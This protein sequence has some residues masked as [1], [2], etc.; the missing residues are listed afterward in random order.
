MDRDDRALTAGRAAATFYAP[1]LA[2]GVARISLGQEAAHHARVRRLSLGDAVRATSGTGLLGAGVL[3]H[4]GGDA[5]EIRIE[6]VQ[7]VS[8]RVVVRLYVPVGDRE[9]ML[10]LAE[11]A[12]ELGIARWQ[13]VR[14]SR[15]RS[16]A[17]RGEGEAFARKVRA[18]MIAALEQSGGAFLPE[19]CPERLLDQVAGADRA[20]ERYLLDAGGV[21]LLSRA[22]RSRE[23]AIVLGPEG[24]LESQERDV[25]TSAGWLPV[26]VGVNTLRFETAGMAAVAIVHAALA[27]VEP[28]EED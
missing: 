7:H 24:G 16:V 19:Q 26:H 2:P 9:R 1:A 14:F 21:P 12:T 27:P 23:V 17:S 28:I 20:S 11:K 22:P 10:W 8:R 4:A 15:S 5:L 18:R 3:A 13:P 6:Q 25:L